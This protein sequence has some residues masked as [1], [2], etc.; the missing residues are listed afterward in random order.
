MIEYAKLALYCKFDWTEKL[1]DVLSQNKREIDFLENNGGLFRLAAQRPTVD[2]LNIL[3]DHYKEYHLSGDPE[4]YEYKLAK[5]QLIDVVSNIFD[6]FI[7]DEMTDEVRAVLKPYA[8][9]SEEEAAAE[10]ADEA[11]EDEAE[12]VE[13]SEAGVV[14]GLENIIAEKGQAYVPSEEAEPSGDGSISGEDAVSAHGS[15]IL[16]DIL[17]SE[18]AKTGGDTCELNAML[19]AGNIAAVSE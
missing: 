14:R 6:S 18:P 16:G 1:Q 7:D 2:I 3:L 15:S 13:N 9:E 12:E 4:S 8:R 5:S 17:T 19:L 11:E 10:L